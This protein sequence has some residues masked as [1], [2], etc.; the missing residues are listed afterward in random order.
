MKQITE[1][2]VSFET[3]KLLKEKGFRAI[4]NR[5]YNAQY[6]QIRTVSDCFMMDW[7]D[8]KYMKS[9]TMP[10]AIAIPTHQTALKWLREVHNIDIIAPPQFDNVE[11][12][13]SPI[14]FKLLIPCTEIRLN[15]NKHKKELAVEA[16]LLYVL[17]NLI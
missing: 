14:I 7:N 15:D 6:D 9:I 5:Y 16:A 8:E 12:T 11:W 3:A 10:G 17:K 13:Y 4:T 2:Y 1:D